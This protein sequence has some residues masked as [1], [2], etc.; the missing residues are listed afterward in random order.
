MSTRK[1][2]AHALAADVS[3]GLDE[4]ALMAKYSLSGS[5]LKTVIERLLQAQL[6][7]ESSLYRLSKSAKVHSEE[8]SDSSA[9]SS[10]HGE[11][12]PEEFAE[13]CPHCGEQRKKTETECHHCGIVFSKAEQLDSVMSPSQIA[14]G[15]IDPYLQTGTYHEL[16]AST[17]YEDASES[18]ERKRRN[19]LWI[20]WTAVALA[21]IPFPLA[22]FG[23]GRQVALFYTLAALL[24]VFLYYLVVVYY[25]WQQSHGWG[26]LCFWFSPAAIIF[27]ILNWNGVF[28]EKFLPKLW[29]A[30]MGPLTV[31]IFL[32]KY[33]HLSLFPRG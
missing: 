3:A 23:Y 25:A 31:V 15:Q 8:S 12:E 33:C 4:A 10:V 17:F 21:I 20:L 14:P 7:T 16:V 22:L 28:S 11:S 1:L 9:I 26:L 5:Q 29:L 19:R 18:Q 24:F 27:V 13:E 6:I 30:I 32:E 2:N